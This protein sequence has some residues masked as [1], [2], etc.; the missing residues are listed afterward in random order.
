MAFALTAF[1]YPVSTYQ[2]D[3]QQS[4][5]Q[6]DSNLPSLKAFNYQTWIQTELDSLTNWMYAF[7]L[8]WR[9]KWS[10]VEFWFLVE[11]C[12]VW[13]EDHAIAWRNAKLDPVVMFDCDNSCNILVERLNFETHLELKCNWAWPLK[14]G[15][16][17]ELP[18]RQPVW[19]VAFLM[20]PASQRIPANSNSRTCSDVCV[21]ASGLSKLSLNGIFLHPS[22]T[23]ASNLKG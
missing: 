8:L 21:A 9:H 4:R 10:S 1:E 5:R 19:S 2:S 15:S 6:Q 11:D 16:H 14:L 3:Q 18:S 22:V 13:K 17:Y 20:F 23:P 7:Y 12:K